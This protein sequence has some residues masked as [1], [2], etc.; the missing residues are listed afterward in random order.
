MPPSAG[1]RNQE[2][3]K[4][5][6]VVLAGFCAFL[7][8]YAPQPLLPSLA[9]EFGRS[10]SGISLVIT[11]S[12]LGVALAAP[13]VGLLGDRIGP[14]RIIVP[15]VIASAV[16]GALAAMTGS[17]GAMLFWRFAQGVVTPGIFGATVAYITEEWEGRTGA[18]ISAYVSGTVIGGFSGRF[19]AALIGARYSW[20]TAFLALSV[21]TAICAVAL[22]RLLP[23]GEGRADRR[24]EDPRVIFEHLRNRR[25]LATYMG[26][27]CVLFTLV[28][29]FTYI[30]FYL[31]APP[32]NLGTVALGLVF[33]AYPVSAVLNAILGR[34]IDRLGHR[35]SMMT[36]FA[37]SILGI[38]LTLNHSL[39]VI[40]TGLS[41]E[42]TGIF[43]A[44]SIANSYIGIVAPRGRAAAVGLYVSAYYFGGTLGSAVPGMFWKWN[45]WIACVALIVLVQLTTIGVAG[46]FWRE[47]AA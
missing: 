18:A 25:L 15:S 27:L 5:A 11:V 12:T 22:W 4:L 2:R 38:L 31:A 30:N 37:G 42:C 16:T 3:E 20:Q 36:A 46:I 35:L 7:F 9:R 41:I 47:E 43:L 44:Q 10:A 19:L 14:G 29:T 28:A 33:V 32:F 39:A 6:A 24:R 26:G 21:A 17:F 34:Y 13:F 45:G 1:S 23:A 8:L 40:V